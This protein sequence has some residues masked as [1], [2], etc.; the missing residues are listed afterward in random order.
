MS[1]STKCTIE[2]ALRLAT[3][4]HEGQIDKQGEPYIFHLITVMELC[5]Q[6]YKTS[7]SEKLLIAAI[8]H[9]IVEDSNCTFEFL[10]DQGVSSEDIGIINSLTKHP[11]E[12]YMDYLKRLSK[13]SNAV[14]IKKM[15]ILHNM[16]R[17]AG[18]P[19]LDE[20]ERLSKKY[21]FA[22]AYLETIDLN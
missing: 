7:C 2:R 19:D 9:D 4:F 14:R 18:I 6:W 1:S 22:S 11:D 17:I 16:S 8:L 10:M 20:R 12:E 13:N 21:E 5:K 15:D 3:H